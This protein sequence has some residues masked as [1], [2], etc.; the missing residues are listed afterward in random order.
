MKIAVS[1]RKYYRALITIS[2]MLAE[3]NFAKSETIQNSTDTDGY[4]RPTSPCSG[5]LAW[6]SRCW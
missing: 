4:K 6:T 3:L 2:S 5:L 1:R